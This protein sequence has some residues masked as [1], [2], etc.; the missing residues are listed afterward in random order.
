MV[1]PTGW[2]LWGVVGLVVAFMLGTAGWVAEAAPLPPCNNYTHKEE[3]GHIYVDLRFDK[4]T[5]HYTT[6]TIFL[7]V[8][9]PGAAPGTYYWNNVLN[10]QPGPSHFEIKDNNF[11]TILRMNDPVDHWAFGDRYKMQ[12]THYS[13]VTRKSYVAAYNECVI[14]PR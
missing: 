8:D 11:H 14:T 9:D 13:P 1:Y 10:G 5:G 3:G 7:F 4:A 6:L 2:W 12:A